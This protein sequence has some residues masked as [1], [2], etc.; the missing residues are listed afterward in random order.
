MPLYRRKPETVE[1]RQ[2]TGENHDDLRAWV[3]PSAI[4]RS[5]ANPNCLLWWSNGRGHGATVVSMGSWFVQRYHGNFAVRRPES[6]AAT[7]EQVPEGEQ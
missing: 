3:G 2:W 6:F 4:E 1:A 5:S 7:Y